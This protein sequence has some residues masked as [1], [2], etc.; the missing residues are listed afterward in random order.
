MTDIPDESLVPLSL[1]HNFWTWSA[2]S[3]VNPI[4]IKSAKGVYFWDIH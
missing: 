1:E 2:Q 3:K 4:P